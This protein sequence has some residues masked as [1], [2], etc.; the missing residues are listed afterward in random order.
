M[1]RLGKSLTIYPLREM[2]GQIEKYLIRPIIAGIVVAFLVFGVNFVLGILSIQP[3]TVIFVSSVQSIV[4]GIA[5]LWL[6]GILVYIV[7][8]EKVMEKVL[9]GL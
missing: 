2:N 7:W 5:F 6:G 1:A 4:G 3:F 8:S 9:E